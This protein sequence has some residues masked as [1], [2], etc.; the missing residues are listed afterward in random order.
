MCVPCA[1]PLLS[2]WFLFVAWQQGTQMFMIMSAVLC[3]KLDMW[4]YS[5]EELQQNEHKQ[6]EWTRNCILWKLFLRSFFVYIFIIL[7]EIQFNLNFFLTTTFKY[8]I[9]KLLNRYDIYF[10]KKN[11]KNRKIYFSCWNESFQFTWQGEVT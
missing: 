4:M 1:W 3:L 11:G 8:F 6:K 9:Q 5:S 7:F 2:C 10:R